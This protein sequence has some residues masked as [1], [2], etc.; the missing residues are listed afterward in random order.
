[1]VVPNINL[2]NGLFFEWCSLLYFY[3]NELLCY[4]QKLD[5]F[6]PITNQN[7][8]GVTIAIEEAL[9]RSERG[10]TTSI[11]PRGIWIAGTTQVP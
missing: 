7:A 5:R 11:F 3:R 9:L 8:L 1:M 10:R 4:R 6:A 2:Y